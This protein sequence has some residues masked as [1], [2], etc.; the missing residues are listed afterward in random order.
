MNIIEFLRASNE[1]GQ[2]WIN[3]GQFLGLLS[4]NEYEPNSICNPNGI[5]G[6]SYSVTSIRNPSGLYGSTWGIYSPYNPNSLCPPAIVY[7]G[8][9]VGFVTKNRHLCTNG[10]STIDPDLL[11]AAYSSNVHA[12]PNPLNAYRRMHR[13]TQN[14]VTSLSQ[15]IGHGLPMDNRNLH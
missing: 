4:S 3:D 13:D 10:L 15:S 1:L 12:A 9:V 11:F 14:F 7:Q 6:S 8:Q 5:Y 2:L